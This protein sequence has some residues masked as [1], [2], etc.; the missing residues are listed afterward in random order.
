MTARRAAVLVALA[1]A[2]PASAQPVV[3]AETPRPGDS[4]R[5]TLDLKLTG[6]LV[7]TENGTKQ[8]VRLDAAARHR[9]A[10]KVL[11]VAEGLPARSARYYDEAVATATVGGDK[12][13]RTLPADR[14]LVIAQRNP[15][16]VFGYC[17]AGPVTREELD[18]VTEHFDPHC[19]A[20]LLP[21]KAVAVGDTWPVT[22]PAAQAAGL[23][24]GLTKNGLRGKFVAAADG[25]ATFTVSG[26]LEGVENGAKVVLTVDATGTFDVS[27]GRITDLTWKQTDDRAAGP[28]TPAAKVEASITVR[29]EFGA[30]VPAELAAEALAAV[31]ADP[32]AA[33]GRLRQ[34]GPRGQYE[35]VHPRD[36]HVTGM[37][38]THLVLRLL[39]GGEFVAQAT[40]SP[41]AKAAP[42]QHAPADEFKK[43]AAPGWVPGRVVED[44]EVPAAAGHWVYR[45]AAEGKSQDVPVFRAAYLVAG[46]RGDQVVVTVV[47]PADRARV[48]AGRD[49]AL[50]TGIGF[51]R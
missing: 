6:Q 43:A 28:V 32:P 11:A 38:D 29:R 18:L 12:T 42:G 35:L 19:L 46:P 3:L 40:V 7:L 50:A 8:A 1:F 48:L 27:A 14:K 34:P 22:N 41:W 31:P 39:D 47:A 5:Y 10:E 17:P 36:W 24:D 30:G 21:G 16:G 13:E 44:G 23:F 9:F 26:P 49:A 15:D 4:A 2:P 20:G 51:G 37:T 45:L 33:A 25:K